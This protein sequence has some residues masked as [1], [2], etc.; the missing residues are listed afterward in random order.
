MRNILHLPGCGGIT[1]QENDGDRFRLLLHHVKGHPAY[2]ID[3][4]G[5]KPDQLSGLGTEAI[6]IAAMIEPQIAAFDPAELLQLLGS[7]SDDK[8]MLVYRSG[9][10]ARLAAR[11]PREAT[12]LPCH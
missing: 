4:I 11:A 5:C 8:C 7:R 6:E 9:A 1:K 10:P 2:R 3:D 12:P